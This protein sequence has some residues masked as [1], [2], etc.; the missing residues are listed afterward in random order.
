ME[1]VFILL[2]VMMVSSITYLTITTY[3]FSLIP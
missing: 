2:I 3:M 1:H